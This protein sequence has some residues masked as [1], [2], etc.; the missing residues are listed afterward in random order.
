MIAAGI[1][2]SAA[3]PAPTAD[4]W[5]W[6]IFALVYVGIAIGT[7]PFTRLSRSAIALLGAIAVVAAGRMSFGVATQSA[8][9][10]TTLA[11]LFA[12]MVLSASLRVAG[13]YARVIAL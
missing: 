3:A 2:A 5:D 12:L 10:W 13:F 1:T 9:D 11:L 4:A 6:A 8:I 7:I